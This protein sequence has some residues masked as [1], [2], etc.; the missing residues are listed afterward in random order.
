M[1]GFA[2]VNDI[3]PTLLDL[4]HVSRP[5]DTYNGRKIEPMIGRSLLPVLKGEAERVHPADEPIGYELSGNQ[6]V[7][8]GD[9]KLLKNIP[10][11]GDGQWHLYDIVNDPGETKDLQARLPDV[12]KAMQAD[13]AA[14]AKANQVLPMPDGY[15][16]THQVLVNA[17]VNV[18]VPR[19]KGPFIAILA[20][21]AALS[22]AI[23]LFRRRR[24]GA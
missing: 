16:P 15:E 7:F 20:G 18:Y 3:V 8:K 9:L 10:P 14:Y 17:I 22:V 2:H 21:L 4:A 23:V 11:V 12:F 1:N 19:F 5:G 13:Y 24:R 6:A